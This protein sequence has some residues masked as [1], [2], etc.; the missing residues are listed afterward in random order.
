[1]A[2]IEKRITDNGETS[3]R[4]K[5]RLKGYPV[6]TATFKR[7]TDARKWTQDTESAIREGRHF[8]TSEAKKH[9]LADLVDRYIKDVLPK[10][11]KQAHAQRPQLERWKSELGCYV[12]A[13]ITP[14]LIVECRDKLLTE[15][16]PRGEQ[17]SP[18]TVVRYMAALSHAF[19]IAVNEWQWLEISPMS[20]VKKPTEPR[21]R[22]RFLDDGERSKLLQACKESPN[23][24]LYLCVIL[25][26]SS[27]MRQ[28][29]LMGLKWQDVNLKDG[30]LILHETKNGDRR[31]VP[32]SGLGL[33]LLQEYAKIRRIDTPFLFPSDRNPQQPIDLRKAF[34]NAMTVAEIT[35]FKW[36]DLRHCTASYLAM[37]GASLAEIAEVLGH[38]TL[39]MVKRYAHLSDG[40]V[41]TVVASMNAKIFSGM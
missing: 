39:S 31:R 29:E 23:P 37:N 30:Y 16:T 22:V 5:I 13:D 18:A 11:P 17:R 7:L 12:L 26:L 33:Q 3:Y 28:A 41:S 21:G 40:H 15:I 9:T 6:Q 24:M 10:K 36:H 20:K 8:K 32:L 2:T 25:A 4:V 14:A 34:K 38:K 27:G 19:T 1:M 35:E